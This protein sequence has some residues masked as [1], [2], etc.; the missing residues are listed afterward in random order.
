VWMKQGNPNSGQISRVTVCVLT[1]AAI[2]GSRFLTV[3]WSVPTP[4]GGIAVSPGVPR[5]EK[6]AV[7][8]SEP[9]GAPGQQGSAR[10]EY[11]KAARASRMIDALEPRA[12]DDGRM[13]YSQADGWVLCRRS[14]D[15]VSENSSLCKRP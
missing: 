2:E 9:A 4:R 10:Q 5:P 1:P 12:R 14:G 8:A 13:R 11:V 15:A 3:D 7:P 6:K